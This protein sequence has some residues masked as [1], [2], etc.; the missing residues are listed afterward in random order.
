MDVA[1]LRAKLADHIGKAP[2]ENFQLIA[3]DLAKNALLC[4]YDVSK[5]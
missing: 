4:D 1:Q 5:V 3:T 2:P